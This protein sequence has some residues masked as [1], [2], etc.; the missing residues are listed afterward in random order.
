MEWYQ[1]LA[2]PAWTPEPS[3]IRWVWW[4]LYPVIGVSF[5]F[6]FTQTIRGRL[7]WKRALPFAVNLVAN[8]AFTPLLFGARDL[9]LAAGDILLVWATIPWMAAVVWPRHR[10]VA[11]AQVP[12]FVWVSIATLLQLSIAFM[13]A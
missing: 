8:L 2:K 13:N 9:R 4:I 6:V 10:W 7:A 1:S 3:T 12:Y 5:G 11:L